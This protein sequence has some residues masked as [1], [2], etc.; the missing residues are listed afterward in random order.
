[1]FEGLYKCEYRVDDAVGR[2]VMYVHNG[3]MLG[4][5]S[6]FAHIGTYQTSNGEILAEIESRRFSR[7][8][9]PLAAG[10]RRVPDQRS[11]QEV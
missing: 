7:S 5:N 1:M 10:V 6:A 11:R 8:E 9:L 3:S 4:G 2:S